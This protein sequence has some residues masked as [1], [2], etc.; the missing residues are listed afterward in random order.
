MAIGHTEDAFPPAFNHCYIVHADIRQV[1]EDVIYEETFSSLCYAGH[2]P[3]FC[4]N[5]NKYGFVFTINVIEALDILSNKT[6]T[7]IYTSINEHVY[8]LILNLLN[9][10]NNN[11]A[12]HFLTRALLSA[13][14]MQEALQVIRDT[15]TGSAHGFCVN[16]AF[17]LQ[18]IDN[19]FLR[20]I[21]CLHNGSWFVFVFFV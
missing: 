14:D 7:I 10:K 9:L 18:V 8:N 21:F 4:M 13:R 5:F 20:F 1:E 11:K 3:G 16:M 19:F 6:R 2:L 17:L 15:G 12:R